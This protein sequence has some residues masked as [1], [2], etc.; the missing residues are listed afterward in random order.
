MKILNQVDD[1]SVVK[2]L[3]LNEYN[4]LIDIVIENSLNLNGLIHM[5]ELIENELP[6]ELKFNIPEMFHKSIIGNGGLIIQSIMKKYN[7][8][9]KFSSQRK[10]STGG[11]NNY[12]GFKRFNNVLIKCPTKNSSNIQLV[13]DEIDGL[14]VSCCENNLSHNYLNK[15]LNN[16]IYTSID[17]KLLK[18][19]YL[20]LINNF[21][22]N[23]MNNLEIEHQSFIDWPNYEDFGDNQSKDISIKG[24]DIKLKFFVTN[25]INS[26]PTNY[27]VSLN[28][29]P[30]LNS[31]LRS[32]RF[33]EEVLTPIKLFHNMEMTFFERQASFEIWLS[34]YDAS[35]LEASVELLS[36]FFQ[37]ENLLIVEKAP[38]DF[39]PLTIKLND[40]KLDNDKK[41][42]R[43]PNKPFS[44]I[45]NEV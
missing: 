36:S 1:A 30:K 31:L 24:S 41:E 13:K 35:K 34:F 7:V 28:R 19:H 6:F 23:T 29:H 32:T 42:R 8:Y 33:T 27:K 9:I 4:F 21:K 22:L 25:L 10:D 17:F 43:R 44:K 12:Y 11:G 45:T 38:A 20:L 2:F 40:M 16:S 5:I 14:M 3:D 26:L 15:N 39:N 18:S 37:R